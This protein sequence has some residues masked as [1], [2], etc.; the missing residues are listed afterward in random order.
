MILCIFAGVN[1]NA[2]GLGPPF[3]TARTDRMQKEA[4]LKVV[5][6]WTEGTPFF[7]VD[8]TVSKDNDIEIEFDSSEGDVDIEDC[9]SLSQFIESQF[10]RSVEDFSLEVGSAGL[11]Q[12]F[13]VIQQFEKHKGDEVEVLPNTGKKLKGTLLTVDEAGFQLEVVKKVKSETGKKTVTLPEVLSF[14]HTDV[15]RVSVVVHF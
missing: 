15:K 12:P 9:V 2:G 3:L 8:A 5:E 4:L 7:L 11:G 13:K 6:Q 1:D 14:K 10:D